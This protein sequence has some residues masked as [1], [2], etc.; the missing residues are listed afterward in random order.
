MK[1][2]TD[3]HDT[4]IPMIH[5]ALIESLRDPRC[6]P[7][8]VDRLHVVETHISWIVLTGSYA[9]K[10]KKPVNLGFLDFSTLEARR[11]HRGHLRRSD[12]AGGA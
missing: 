6:Y 5:G 11:R 8:R 3:T 10:I 12:S 4:M 7:H 9:Y 2:A 1:F